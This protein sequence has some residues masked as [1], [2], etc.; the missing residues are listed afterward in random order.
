MRLLN[1]AAL[2]TGAAQGL[3]E[4]LALRLATEGCDVLIT[5]VTEKV[6][7][8]AARLSESTG[9]RVIGMQ[10][11]VTAESD[12]ALMVEQAVTAF[13]KLDVFVANAGIVKAGDVTELAA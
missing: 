11:D 7:A 5:D 4:A 2:I 10:A 12:C 9:R 3:G 6:M 1:K 8:T 13:G